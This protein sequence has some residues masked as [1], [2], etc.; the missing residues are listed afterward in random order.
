MAASQNTASFSEVRLYFSRAFRASVQQQEELAA[1]V[2]RYEG[3]R[4]VTLSVGTLRKGQEAGCSAV[5]L[6][7]KTLDMKQC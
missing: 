5:W 1:C 6:E 7:S 2:A 3:R 4:S